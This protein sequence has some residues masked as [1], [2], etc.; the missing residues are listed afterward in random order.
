[1]AFRV[2]GWAAEVAGQI[3]GLHVR[4]E[5]IRLMAL[6]ETP[7]ECII[8]AGDIKPVLDEIH[9][10]Q[11]GAAEVAQLDWLIG[12]YNS[13]LKQYIDREHQSVDGGILDILLKQIER[14]HNLSLELMQHLKPVIGRGMKNNR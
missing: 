12:Y 13:G 4:A 8:P 6:I 5:D 10:L 7:S 3:K 2:I 1:M 14:M 11:H 9:Y